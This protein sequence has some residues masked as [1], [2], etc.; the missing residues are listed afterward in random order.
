M[1][2]STKR[3]SILL[4]IILWFIP[5]S[6]ILAQDTLRVMY[7]N[8]LNYPGSTPERVSHFRIVNLYVQ[9]DILLVNELISDDGASMLLEDGLNVNGNNSYKK[10]DFTNGPD[11]DNML[12]YDS[13]KVTLYSQDI[14]TT[15]LRH[16]NEYVLYNNAPDYDTIFYHMYSAHL[17]SSTGSVNQ[18]KRLAEVREFKAWI[19][20]K[21]VIENI[22]FGGD[23][24]FYSSSEPAYDTLVNYGVHILNDPL[25]AGDWHDNS[26]HASIHSQSTRTSQFGGGAS[27]G[28]DDRFDFILYSDDVKYGTNGVNY[29]SNSCK[30]IGNDGNHFNIAIIDP[31]TNTSVPDSV[32]Q[33]LYYMS[34]HMPVIC[35]LE[36]NL[37]TYQGENIKLGIEIDVFP[38]PASEL[39]TIKF[40]NFRGQTK[41]NLINS[42]GVVLKKREF[43]IDGNSNQVDFDLSGM[44]SGVYFIGVICEN[45][46]EVKKVIVY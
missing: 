23:F 4:V 1:L 27:G 34:D 40:D 32:L 25:T 20:S 6:N 14:I 5:S 29:I 18:Q 39:V 19:D 9:P 11:S 33:A 2:L 24:N 15:E 30:S 38:N 12:F 35:D 43:F 45:I 13:T 21:P 42:L 36:I 16:I 26:S 8:I 37:G 7:Y 10:A 17:K 46:Q 31:P 3:I 28:L 44:Q 41:V 22:F